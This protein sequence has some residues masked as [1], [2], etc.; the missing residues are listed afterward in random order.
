ME[1]SLQQVPVRASS[2][3]LLCRMMCCAVSLSMSSLA[4]KLQ[5]RRMIYHTSELRASI[6]SPC[7]SA[8][9]GALGV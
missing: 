1:A 8:L 3:L 4:R 6:I 2:A 9:G 7:C 5:L